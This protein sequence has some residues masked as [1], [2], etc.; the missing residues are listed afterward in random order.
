MHKLYDCV[1]FAHDKVMQAQDNNTG[2][3][4]RGLVKHNESSLLLF[5][6]MAYHYVCDSI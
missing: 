5:P 1:Q 2:Y 6:V 3:G 4:F